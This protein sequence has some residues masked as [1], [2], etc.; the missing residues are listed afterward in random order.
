MSDEHALLREFTVRRSE[1]AFRELVVG[2]TDFVFSAALRQCGPA[3]AD[4]ATQQ[5]F[6]ALA[7]KAHTLG[8]ASQLGGWLHRHT[9]FV[10][11]NLVRAEQ[12]RVLREKIAMEIQDTH[13]DWQHV[14]PELDAAMRGIR[15]TPTIPF[16]IARACLELIACF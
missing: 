3:Q 12:R 16:G 14:A 2:Y 4:D 9:R 7:Q 13:A 1:T 6:I 10:S 5:V 15:L 8:P 11:L